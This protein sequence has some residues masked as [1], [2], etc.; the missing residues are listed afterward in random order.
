MEYK[1]MRTPPDSSLNTRF[2]NSSDEYAFPLI[3]ASPAR[4]EDKSNKASPTR[5]GEKTS[6]IRGE[7]KKEKNLS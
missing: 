1:K 6:P 7:E 2:D 3:Y 4:G 5:G